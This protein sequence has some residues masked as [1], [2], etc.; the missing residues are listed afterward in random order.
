MLLGS[1]KVTSVNMWW[2][3]EANPDWIPSQ[4]SLSCRT[5]ILP[6]LP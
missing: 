4:P 3:Q 1:F 2:R 6:L 5:K